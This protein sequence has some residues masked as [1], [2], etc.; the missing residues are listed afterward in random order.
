MGN[1]GSFIIFLSVINHPIKSNKML[2]FPFELT[3]FSRNLPNHSHP[4][5]IKTPPY[6]HLQDTALAQTHKNSK[7]F[8]SDHLIHSTSRCAS[9]PPSQ[10]SSLS[11]SASSLPPPMQPPSTSSTNAP[12]PS[13]QPP[14]PVVDGDLTPAS[15]GQS[16]STPA[17]PM[18]ASG[19]EPHAPSTPMGV[20]NAKLVT[21]MASSNARA[22]VHPQTPSLN[23]L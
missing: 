3:H 1:S 17:P 13:G 23:S 12:T 5:S 4:S 21:A 11:S 2:K 19:A 6:I 22:T 7:Y 10:F 16:P 9:T 18:L 15:P 8:D 14:P 20:A